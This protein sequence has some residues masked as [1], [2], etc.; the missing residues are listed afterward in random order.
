MF[1]GRIPHTLDEKGRLSVPSK[2]RDVLRGKYDGRVIITSTPNHL[3]VY[4]YEE[5]RKLE[6]MVESMQMLPPE[7]LAFKRYYFSGGVECSMDSQNRILIPQHLRDEVGIEREVVLVGMLKYFEIWDKARLDDE[8]R[9]T[10][11]NFESYSRLFSEL[12]ARVTKL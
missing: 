8:L 7:L 4:P 1:R 2:Y 12:S 11:D 9:K 6:D 5:W 10:R 3:E